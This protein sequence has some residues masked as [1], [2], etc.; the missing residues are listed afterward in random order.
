MSRIYPVI[1]E[2][3][4]A[5]RPSIA[6]IGRHDADLARQMRKAATSVVCNTGEGMYSRGKLRTARYHIALG[7]MRESLSCIEAAVAL[8]YV[9]EVDPDIVMR[10]NV[11]IGTLVRLVRPGR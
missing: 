1:L 2:T 10:V 4:Q 11:V 3:L 6:Q 9:T 7:S 8:G 5:L